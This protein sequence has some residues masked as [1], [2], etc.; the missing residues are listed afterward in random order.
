[1][2]KRFNLFNEFKR[3]AHLLILFASTL[4]FLILYFFISISRNILFYFSETPFRETK[5]HSPQPLG[6]GL[7]VRFLIPY[8]T[9]RKSISLV[10]ATS[11]YIAIQVARPSIQSFVCCGT[12]QETEFANVVEWTITGTIATPKS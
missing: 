11:A 1:M 10:I 7:G 9:N 3:L 12:P 5:S 8:A 4:L 6:E 2:F